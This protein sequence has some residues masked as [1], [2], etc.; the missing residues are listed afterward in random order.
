MG[1]FTK[2]KR[3]SKFQTYSRGDVYYRKAK[4]DGFRARSAYKLMHIDEVYEIFNNVERCIDIC[5]APGSW[6]QF[7]SRKL[8]AKGLDI[9]NETRIVSVDLQKMAPIEGVHLIEGDITK[10]S[11]VEAIIDAFGGNKAELVV[12]DGAPDVTGFHDIDQ[13]IQSQL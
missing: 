1:K 3:V 13:Y 7:I 6:S 2:D 4:E 12:C 11:T 8:A 9:K 5:A 10:N